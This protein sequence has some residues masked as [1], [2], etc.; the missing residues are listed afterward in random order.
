MDE[1]LWHNVRFGARLLTRRLRGPGLE[2]RWDRRVFRVRRGDPVARISGPPGELLL[3][4]FGR[5]RAA[6][7]EVTGPAAAV[8]ALRGAHLGM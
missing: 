6:A 5:Q 1:A 7:V 3:Y 2:V 8:E 4:L